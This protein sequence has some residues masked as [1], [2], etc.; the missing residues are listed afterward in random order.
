M[1]PHRVVIVVVL[2][3]AI[4]CLLAHESSAR[5]AL[6][7]SDAE[8]RAWVL[9][10][11]PLGSTRKEVLATIEREHWSGHSWYVGPGSPEWEQHRYFKYCAELGTYRSFFPPFF[12]FPCRVFAYWLFGPGDRVIQVFVSSACSGL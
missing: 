6:R 1:K 7:R 10:K 4:G 3:L 11:T 2:V 12:V 5:N 9:Q 8:I